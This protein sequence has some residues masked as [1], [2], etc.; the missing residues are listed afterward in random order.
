MGTLLFGQ[1]ALQII[2]S[3]SVGEGKIP[4]CHSNIAVSRPGSHVI[5]VGNP[6]ERIDD[7]RQHRGFCLKRLFLKNVLQS[8]NRERELLHLTADAF[9]CVRN[10]GTH[11]ERNTKC[12]RSDFIESLLC[13]GHGNNI[14]VLVT[15]IRC[16]FE[17]NDLINHFLELVDIQNIVGES[18][19]PA[20]CPGSVLFKHKAQNKCRQIAG[21]KTVWCSLQNIINF[22]NGYTATAVLEAIIYDSINAH[23]DFR[24]QKM[25]FGNPVFRHFPCTIKSGF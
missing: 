10:R 6:A 7:F 24:N 21:H 2:C 19:A 20:I 14:L 1:N 9:S 11:I 5:T 8:P 18:I 17:T 13:R 23:L 22:L 12:Y 25:R 3:I 15:R 16:N 4:D